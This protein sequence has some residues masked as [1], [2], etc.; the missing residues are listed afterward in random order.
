MTSRNHD[1]ALAFLAALSD[2]ELPDTLLAPDFTAW[3]TTSGTNDKARYQGGIRL[4]G[5]LFPQQLAYTA[6]SVTAEDDRVAIEAQAEGILSTG[7]PFA[8]RYVFILQ[9]RDGRIFSVAEHFHPDP[10]REKIVPLIQAAM[11]RNKGG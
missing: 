10:V 6:H 11:A 1:I 7:E 2:G 9:I 8:N 3:T 5:A 4:L